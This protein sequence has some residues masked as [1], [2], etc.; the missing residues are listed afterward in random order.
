MVRFFSLF[1]LV[2][3]CFGFKEALVAVESECDSTFY[4]GRRG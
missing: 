1:L 3:Y 2:Q 4:T